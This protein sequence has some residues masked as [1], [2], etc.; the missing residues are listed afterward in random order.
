ME[1]VNTYNQAYPDADF[2]INKNIQRDSS[3]SCDRV[4]PGW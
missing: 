3:R 2:D 4:K 1:R